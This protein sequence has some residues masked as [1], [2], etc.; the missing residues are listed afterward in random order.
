MAKVSLMDFAEQRKIKLCRVCQLK[1]VNDLHE[2]R[3]NGVSILAMVEWLDEKEGIKGITRHMV[4][5]HFR[6][7]HELPK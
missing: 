5:H 1:Q 2:G 7:R 3:E 4:E 6:E